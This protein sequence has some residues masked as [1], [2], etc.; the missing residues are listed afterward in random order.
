MACETLVT[1]G[2]VILAGEVKS[3]TYLDLH[4]IARDVINRIGYNKSEYMFDGN[5][6]GIFSSIHEQS[7]DINQGVDR[8]KKEEQGA[9]RGHQ[10]SGR[11]H[12]R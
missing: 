1:F 12:G 4:K 2:Q 11:L 3:K 10:T 8:Q 6:C 7:T 5:S 9:D